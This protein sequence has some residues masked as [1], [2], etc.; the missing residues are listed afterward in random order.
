MLST[1]Q[2]IF[3]ENLGDNFRIYKS[4]IEPTNVFAIADKMLQTPQS[5]LV[6]G[7]GNRYS[8]ENLPS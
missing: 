5:V 2:T 1:S 6:G 8:I 7:L 3:T 4:A